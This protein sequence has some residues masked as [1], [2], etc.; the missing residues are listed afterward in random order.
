MRRPLIRESW[1]PA[2][3]FSLCLAVC[4]ISSPV[5]KRPRRQ[6]D[7]QR[8]P[9]P[10]IQRTT[11]EQLITHCTLTLSRRPLSR[12]LLCVDYAAGLQGS[13]V[14]MRVAEAF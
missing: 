13:G 11:K 1:R 12:H 3:F 2:I 4:P 9:L 7:T 6:K 5:R 8:L 14:Y 10:T